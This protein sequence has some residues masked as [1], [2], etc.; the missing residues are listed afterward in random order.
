MRTAHLFA[1]AGG[2]LLADIILGHEPAVAVEHD[3][4]CCAVL[5]ERFPGLRVI[6]GDVRTVDFARDLAGVDALCAG[7]P[8]QDISLAGNGRGLDGERSGLFWE[9]MRAVDSLRPEW[10]F[11][12]NSPA[13]R[14]RGR[15]RVLAS[16]MER[17]YLARDGLLSAAAVGAPHRRDRWWCL[18]HLADAPR[19]GLG[20]PRLRTVAGGEEIADPNADMRG[21]EG[22]GDP[23]HRGQQGA[24][25]REPDRLRAR[26]RRDGEDVADAIGYAGRPCRPGDAG[27]GTRGWNP[28]GSGVE[29]D[30]VALP[31]GEGLPERQGAPGERSRAT[32]A[33]GGWWDAEPSVGRVAHGL[34]ARAHRLRALGNGQVPL[35]AAVAWCLLGGPVGEGIL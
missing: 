20:R 8:C 22:G 17:G 24:P 6:E 29:Q 1:G 10:V 9:V 34:A 25:W 23:Q 26:G 4:Y 19:D 2:G 21:R 32:T 14:T 28:C 27:E 35:C 5:R 15:D 30:D 7:F 33:R 12:E 18:A 16:L 31:C 11:L 13:I 3:A